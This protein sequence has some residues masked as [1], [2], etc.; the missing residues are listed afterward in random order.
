MEN[1]FQAK[2]DLVRFKDTFS[3]HLHPHLRGPN[4]QKWIQ[5][6]SGVL[7]LSV[8]LV[9]VFT[10]VTIP[11][12]GKSSVKRKVIHSDPNFSKSIIYRKLQASTTKPVIQKM[13]LDDIF[14]SV[15]TSK[16]FHESR[17]KVILKTWFQLAKANT[18]FFTDFSD[19]ETSI[20]T[21]GHL[22]VT[23]C[24]SDHSRQA[25]SCKMQAEFDTFLKSE[26]SWFCHFD[27]DQYVNVLALEDKLRRFDS[28]E[29][30]YLG[31]PSIE[32]PLEILDRDS[33]KMQKKVSFWFATGGAGFC[34]SKSLAENMREHAADGKFSSVADKMRLPD[35]VTMG[36]VVE[37]L[38]G[39]PMTR[40]EEFHSHLEPLRLVKNLTKQISFSYSSYGSEKNIIEVNGFGEQED[41]TRFQSIHCHLFPYF[42]WCPSSTR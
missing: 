30:W 3:G 19:E 41:P 18:Y 15:K 6:S 7:V 1:K 42:N 4:I 12:N 29:D 35:D 5:I 16:K 10:L 27:D 20:L 13:S 17:L 9:C 37:L 11:K 38:A 36:Y 24:P 21:N 28:N 25:L 40:I 33:P 32:R 14:I 22:I 34:L 8:V 2:S 31:K 39:V 26:K 23:S